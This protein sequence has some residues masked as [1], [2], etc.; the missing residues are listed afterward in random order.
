[1]EKMK[2]SVEV[3][4]GCREYYLK[5]EVQFFAKWKIDFLWRWLVMGKMQGRVEV[6]GEV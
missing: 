3:Y 6:Y 4:G 5:M 1:M 2:G